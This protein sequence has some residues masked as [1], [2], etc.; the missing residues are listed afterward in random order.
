MVPMVALVEL[1]ADQT[2]FTGPDECA[3]PIWQACHY[4]F[5]NIDSNYVSQ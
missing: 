2:L 4:T 1:L 5:L 3:L